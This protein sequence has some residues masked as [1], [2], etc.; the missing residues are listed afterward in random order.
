M[1]CVTREDYVA[2]ILN[3][4]AKFGNIAKAYVVRLNDISGLTL[5]TLSYNQRRQLVQTPPLVLNNLR[6][7][8]E[9]FRMI[10]DALDFG[11]EL[12]GGQFSGYKINFGVYFEITADRR[13]NK[14]DVKLEVIQCIKNYFK[15]DKM[16]FAQAINLGELKYEILGKDGVIGCNQLKIFQS[17]GE[18]DGFSSQSST[19]RDL[20]TFDNEGNSNGNIGYGWSYAFHNALQNDII[21]P[22]ATPSVFELRN[23]NTDIYGRVI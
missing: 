7:Y 23:P 13:F 6:M 10:N 11:F 16:Q 19:N 21:R 15:T 5:Y 9:Q 20:F 22:S 17:T 18:I 2:R 8:L 14:S 3:L 4:P 1:R 12:P